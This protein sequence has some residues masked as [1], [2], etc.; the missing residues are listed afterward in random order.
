MFLEP[1]W[2]VSPGFV[3]GR[4]DS[5]MAASNKLFIVHGQ[6][7]GRGGQKLRMEDDLTQRSVRSVTLPCT[8]LRVHI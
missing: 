6:Q 8:R 2:C 4:K 5:K 1:T 7:R 3:V